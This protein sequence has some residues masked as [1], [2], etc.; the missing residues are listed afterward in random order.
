MTHDELN[1]RNFNRLA[2]AAFGGLIAGTSLG[3]RSES[4]PSGGL[5]P[6][7]DAVAAG[8]KNLCRGLNDCRGQG[9]GGQN[10]CRGQGQCATYDR[11]SCAS[12]NA[13]KGQGGCGENPGLN[14]CK[15]QGGC[16]VPLM[17]SAWEN[18]RARKEQEW[19]AE[20]QTFGEAPA[21]TE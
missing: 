3:C 12:E 7:G 21:A 14:A 19:K 11:H 10:D 2:A 20:S 15:G 18:V 17:A 8:D 9:Y 1:R 6:E 4:E 16:S 13:C 5:P